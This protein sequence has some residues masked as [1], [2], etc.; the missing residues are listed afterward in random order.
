MLGG[1]GG[2]IKASN[3][4]QSKTRSRRLQQQALYQQPSF[5][6]TN[7]NRFQPYNQGQ[8]TWAAQ[9]DKPQILVTEQDLKY[10]L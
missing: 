1:A 4:L 9:I 6:F 3:L 7:T 2:F 5:G 10:W 8:K